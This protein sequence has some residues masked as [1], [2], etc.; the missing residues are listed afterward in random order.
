MD[1]EDLRVQPGVA[2][3][4]GQL[5][6]FVGAVDEPGLQR[7]EGSEDVG[8]FLNGLFDNGENLADAGLALAGDLG[9]ERGAAHFD[10]HFRGCGR[11]GAQALDG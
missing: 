1:R 3:V 5:D 11:L 10:R 6:R 2:Y 8:D 7:L 9:V 4:P